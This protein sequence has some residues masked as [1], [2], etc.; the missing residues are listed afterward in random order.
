MKINY[1]KISNTTALIL[2]KIFTWNFFI[3]CICAVSSILSLFLIIYKLGYTLKYP[4][5]EISN[6][7]QI[8]LMTLFLILGATLIVPYLYK[9]ELYGVKFELRKRLDDISSQLE[10]LPDYIL[11]S[12]YQNEED[13]ILAEESYRKALEYCP[14]FWPAHLGLGSIYHTLKQFDKAI[15]HYNRVINKD[16]KV[17]QNIYALNN[18]AEVYIEADSPTIRNYS[19]ALDK[20]NKALKIIPSLGS[21]LYYKAEALNRLNRYNEAIVI[22]NELLQSEQPP[23]QQHWTMYEHAISKSN[24]DQRISDVDLK[25]MLK[26]AKRN[27]ERDI[28]VEDLYK[29][30]QRFATLDRTTVANFVDPLWQVLNKEHKCSQ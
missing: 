7:S 13:Y 3:K 19:E 12:E 15:V 2:K 21:A 28:F 23:K 27:N 20:A 4:H 16:A 8:N 1:Y 25:E 29:D 9:I 14:D 30:K 17:L 6:L 5:I 26:R 10:A 11:G 18:L 24:M 22:L